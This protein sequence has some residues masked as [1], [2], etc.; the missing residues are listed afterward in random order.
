MNRQL[1]DKEIT[2]EKVMWE[3]LPLELAAGRYVLAWLVE[4]ALAAHLYATQTLLVKAAFHDTNIDTNSPDT[5]TSLY[6]RHAHILAT[7]LARM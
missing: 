4:Q 6:V 5:P 7:I 2:K 3:S 1:I